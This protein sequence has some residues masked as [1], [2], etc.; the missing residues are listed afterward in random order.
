MKRYITL[1]LVLAVCI[2]MMLQGAV[3][4][5][6]ATGEAISLMSYN[7]CATGVPGESVSSYQ[8]I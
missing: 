1:L 3:P 4:A 8:M 6:A 7:I 2:P 5:S